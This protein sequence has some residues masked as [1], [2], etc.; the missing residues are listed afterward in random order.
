MTN[1][2][3]RIFVLMPSLLTE[4]TVPSPIFITARSSASRHFLRIDLTHSGG[5]KLMRQTLDRLPRRV[6]RFADLS[7]SSLR[8][9]RQNGKS[10]SSIEQP[11]AILDDAVPSGTGNFSAWG[12][13]PCRP[14]GPGFGWIAQGS[15]RMSICACQRSRGD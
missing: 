6:P 8:F 1:S 11:I 15:D 10:S 3:R 4:R 13:R 12:V 9:Y 2:S 7:D 5:V 14:V